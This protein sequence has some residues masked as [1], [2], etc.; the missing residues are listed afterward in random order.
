MNNILER[1][2][3]NIIGKGNKVLMMAHGFGCDQRTWKFITD[4]FLEDYKIVLFDYVGSGKSDIN[5]YDYHKY[6]SLEGYACDV[7]DI[8]EALNLEDVIFIGHSVS[9]MIGVLAA[10]QMPDVIS[11]LIFIGPSPRYINDESYFG[12]FERDQV[13]DLFKFMAE[14]YLGW[15]KYLA[16]NAMSNPEKP[17]HTEFLQQC[18]EAMNPKVALEFAMATFNCDYRDKLQHLKTPS[19]TLL[20]DNDIIVPLSV[21][22]FIKRQ[23]PYNSIHLLNATGHYPHITAP[24]ETIDAIK[25]YIN[26]NNETGSNTLQYSQSVN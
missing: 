11:K 8:I 19:I 15:A 12:G 1:N 25:L 24:K 16:P 21:G 26:T 6:S 23:T 3:V 10:I 17:E 20:N 13:N 7:V 22:D 2:H 5:Q 9:G 18:F 4:A 14:D